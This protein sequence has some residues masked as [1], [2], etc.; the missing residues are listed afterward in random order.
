MPIVIREIVTEVAL[1]PR[2]PDGEVAPATGSPP[3]LSQE[4]L[5]RVVRRCT[6]RVLETLRREWER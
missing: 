3:A 4:E 1:A 2:P 6:E 5:D